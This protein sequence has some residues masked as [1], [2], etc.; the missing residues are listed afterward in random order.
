RDDGRGEP[1]LRD[2]REEDV[3]PAA[4]VVVVQVLCE[5]EDQRKDD[6]DRQPQVGA[7]LGD[8]LAQLPAPD[9]ERPRTPPAH[10]AGGCDGGR[11]GGAHR[12]LASSKPRSPPRATG[13][14][15]SSLGGVA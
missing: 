3:V 12:A 1:R 5:H 13:S 11:R 7:L 2:L 14:S 15:P 8:E 10:W 4:A 9:R 6:P